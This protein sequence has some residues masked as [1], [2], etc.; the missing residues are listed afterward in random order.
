MKNEHISLT[1]V[2]KDM[3][4]VSLFVSLL[5]TFKDTASQARSKNEI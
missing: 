4:P 1:E 5:L 3:L 2:W